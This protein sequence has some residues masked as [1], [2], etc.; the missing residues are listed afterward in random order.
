M[1]FAACKLIPCL[2]MPWGGQQTDHD[3]LLSALSPAE[4]ESGDLEESG[5]D[6]TSLH[7][8]S[9]QEKPILSRG[10]T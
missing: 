1:L 9:R 7:F 6:C 10:T 4:S 3:L 8:P 2:T 5:L